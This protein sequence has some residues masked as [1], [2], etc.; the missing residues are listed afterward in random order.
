M[1]KRKT[2]EYIFADAF[3]GCFSRNLMTRKDLSRVIAS[4]DLDAADVILK[5]YGYGDSQDLKNGDVEAFIRRE[6][7]NLFD[8]IYNTLPERKELAF[9]LFPFDYHNIKVCL[10][11]EILGVT[12]DDNY[13]ISSGDTDMMKT[14]VMVKE[15][16]Y[17]FMPPLM[18]DAIKEATDLYGR[19]GDPQ[20]IDIVLDKAC[21]RQML[22]AAEETDEEFLVTMVK[23]KIDTL[24]LKAFAR[25]KRLKKPWAFLQRV[26]ID[27]GFIPWNLFMTSYEESLTQLADKFAPYGY[28]EVMAEGGKLLSETGQFWLFEKL[29]DDRLMAENRKAKY[30]LF[31]INPIA[32]YWYG[33]ELEI[34]NLRLILTGK[35]LDAPAEAIEE[36]VREPYV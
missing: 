17:D 1:A 7:N 10:K 14:V 16:N 28:G 31:G 13:L 15:R 8:L 22:E 34:D 3:I 12:P 25:L 19:S 27:G 4:R 35:L 5:E 32:G 36:R 18:K 21:Y 26:F 11:A 2:D 24:N 9:M 30:E 6:Q 33:K 29:C 20:D 23:T